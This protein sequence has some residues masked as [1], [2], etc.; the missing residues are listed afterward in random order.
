MEGDIPQSYQILYGLKAGGPGVIIV[1]GVPV[2]IDPPVGPLLERLLRAS[3]V[4]VGTSGLSDE[5]AQR[6]Q[7]AALDDIAAAAEGLTEAA[8][9]QIKG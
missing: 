7:A 4:F 3:A 6:I 1:G 9:K 2:P 8:S 5:A